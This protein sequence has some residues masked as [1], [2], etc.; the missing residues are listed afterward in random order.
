[1]T[2][3]L[4]LRWNE[5]RFPARDTL[6]MT[7][8]QAPTVSSE[9]NAYA[10]QAQRDHF[11]HFLHSGQIKSF[12]QPIVDLSTSTVYGYEMLA[13]GAGDFV[14]PATMFDIARKVGLSFELDH[15]CREAAFTAVDRH[16][17]G[18]VA[19]YFINTTPE[20]FDDPRF[21]PG[22]TLSLI[23]RYRMQPDD[24][25]LEITECAP[26]G[27]DELLKEQLR[28]YAE[29][30][31]RIALDDFGAGH[32]GLITLVKTAPQFLKLDMGLIRGI[33]SSGY[34]QQL[35]RSLIS[36]TSSTGTQLIA[37]GV[38]TWDEM[39]VLMRFGVRYAQGYLLGRPAPEPQPI[40]ADVVSLLQMLNRRYHFVRND[41]EGGISDIIIRPKTFEEDAINCEDLE[42][43]FKRFQSDDH[44]VLL[45]KN[46]PAGLIT[47]D[48]FYLK[49]GG[50]FGYELFQRK[51]VK[52]LAKRDALV[53]EDGIQATELA[54][55]A[56][57]RPVKDLYDPVIVIDR[58]GRFVGSVTV[59]QLLMR[60]ADLEVRKATETNPLTG[61]PGNRYIQ[62]WIRRA[63]EGQAFTVVY[64]DLDR[65]KEYNDAYGFVKGDEMIRLAARVL[66]DG[67]ES[68]GC[69]VHVG[70]IGGDDFVVIALSELPADLIARMCEQFDRDRCNLFLPEAVRQGWYHATD[71]MGNQVQVPLVTLSMAVIGSQTTTGIQHPG[72]LSQIAASLK[73]KTKAE[74]ARQNRS[75]YL[76]ERRSHAEQPDVFGL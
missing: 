14:S 47:R 72:H 51:P 18:I 41:L 23:H 33:D 34:K 26:L 4:L 59:R 19:K 50:P 15:A 55:L 38:E 56:M 42:R 57:N 68:S 61:L 53:V 17:R 44:V 11:V 45:Q 27:D 75:C 37:E 10:Q 2:K 13:R 65:F 7:M 66:K 24:F 6:N 16:R 62:T 1:M 21:V 36:F 73:K 64:A 25:V 48:N 35:V 3:D 46:R 39:E 60:S 40:P 32:S 76:F 28:H 20:V 12:F 5:F 67:A 63:L 31:L 54:K 58:L 71:R 30:G 22:F 49:T 43:I 70:H 74:S 29:Q 9:P 8:T 69:D 52:M